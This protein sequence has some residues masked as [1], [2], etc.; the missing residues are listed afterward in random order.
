MFIFIS[1]GEYCLPAGSEVLTYNDIICG[2]HFEPS[3][4]NNDHVN[5]NWCFICGLESKGCICFK[6]LFNI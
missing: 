3:I 2:R 4:L 6:F 1:I 5:A